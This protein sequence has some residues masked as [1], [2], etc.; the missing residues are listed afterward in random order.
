MKQSILLSI[1]GKDRAGIVRDVSA[2]LLQADANLED[3]SMTVLRGRFT[4]MLIVEL[5]AGGELTALKASLAEL[6]QHT[7]LNVQ[8]QILNHDEASLIPDEPDCV[9]TVSGADKP[10]IVFAVTD[11]LADVGVSVVDVSTRER[12]GVYMMALEVLAGENMDILRDKLA[13][14]AEK[15]SVSIEIHA[16]DDD[17]M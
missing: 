9:F 4:M 13:Q 15:L 7:G 17:V 5:A 11:V 1:S 3:S 16:L 14:V 10:G 6:E 2:V 8:S 12:D